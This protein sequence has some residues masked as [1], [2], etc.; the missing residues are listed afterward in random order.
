MLFGSGV[1]EAW[2]LIEGESGDGR[3]SESEGEGLKGRY[4]RVMESERNK[5]GGC[6][7]V[8]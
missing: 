2:N 6:S 3:K 1:R 7:L 5:G 8:G 4:A